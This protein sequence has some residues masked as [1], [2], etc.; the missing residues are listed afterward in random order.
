MNILGRRPPGAHRAEEPTQDLTPRCEACRRPGTALVHAA[1]DGI[2]MLLC[3][4]P[5]TCRRN[6]PKEAA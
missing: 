3:A 2:A 1:P 5:A 6:W 4:D